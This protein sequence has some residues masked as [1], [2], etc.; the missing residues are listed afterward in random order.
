MHQHGA[1]KVFPSEVEDILETQP[2]LARACAIGVPHKKWG[3]AVRAVFQFEGGATAAEE[4]NLGWTCDH[5][6]G[7]KRPKCPFP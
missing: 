4:D 2:L 6:V 3:H 1:E 5:I 7:F